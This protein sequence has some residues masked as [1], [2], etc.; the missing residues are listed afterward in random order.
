MSIKAL[1]I[2]TVFSGSIHLL[3]LTLLTFMLL[4]KSPEMF[5][6]DFPKIEAGTAV[7]LSAILFS[8]SF[9]IGRII[10]Q[11]IIAINY[12]F[13]RK[14]TRQTYVKDFKGTPSDIWGNKIFTLSSLIGLLL[15]GTLLFNLAKGEEEKKAICIIGGILCLSTLCSFIYWLCLGKKIKSES[16]IEPAKYWLKRLTTK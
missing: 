14:K 7:L 16:C 5:F 12:L 8:V 3:W 2:E 6:C 1:N 4:G 11:F 10:E 13:S 15:F 9:F